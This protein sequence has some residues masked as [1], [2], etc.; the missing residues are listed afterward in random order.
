[1]LNAL[2]FT[3]CFST[4]ALEALYTSRLIHTFTP[5][6][7]GTFSSGKCFPFNHTMMNASESKLGFS[8]LP[9]DTLAYRQVHTGIKPSTI[10]LVDDL[11]CLLSYS[12]PWGHNL[13]KFDDLN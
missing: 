7:T 3:E 9:K 5:I 1:M 13:P 2:V 8:M 12:L 4:R 11:L 10:Q 6:H